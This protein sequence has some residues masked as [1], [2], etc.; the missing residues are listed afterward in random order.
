MDDEKFCLWAVGISILLF[1]ILLGMTQY[2]EWKS[3]KDDGGDDILTVREGDRVWIDY[4]GRFI[5]SDDKPGTVFDTS[6]GEVARDESIPKSITFDMKPAYDDLEFT[7]GT[8]EMIEGFDEAV[9]GKRVGQTFNVTIPMEKAYGE[10]DPSLI[11]RI[12][13]TEDIE[14]VQIMTMDEFRLQF[15]QVNLDTNKTFI[16]PFWRW[17]VTVID[18]TSDSV[19]ILNNAEYERSYMIFPWNSTITD[20]STERNLITVE[21]DIDEIEKGAKV[22]RFLIDMYSAEPLEDRGMTEGGRPPEDGYVE[23]KGEQIVINF[24][25]EVAGKDLYF[26]ITVN[27]IERG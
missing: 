25:R 17:D 27:K 6:I 1:V 22:P 16:H 8:G 5:A 7:V 24:N 15:P 18:Y 26:Q 3:G 19:T 13:R 23:S 12:N 10:E 20:V 4:T 21:H 2:D 14:L 9:M 11:H